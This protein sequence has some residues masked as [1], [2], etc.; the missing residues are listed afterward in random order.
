[1][2]LALVEPVPDVQP[3][4]SYCGDVLGVYEILVH[5]VNGCPEKTSRAAQPSLNRSSPGRLYHVLCYGQAQQRRPS[6][7]AAT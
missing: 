4:C 5:V 3:H 7:R 2:A 1:M 6:R